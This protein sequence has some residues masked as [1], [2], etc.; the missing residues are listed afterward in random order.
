MQVRF[1]LCVATKGQEISCMGGSCIC[2]GWWN[3]G[4]SMPL[5]HVDMACGG[6]LWNCQGYYEVHGGRC[7]MKGCL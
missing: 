2:I 4:I 5:K 1:W 3:D 6:R 7:K